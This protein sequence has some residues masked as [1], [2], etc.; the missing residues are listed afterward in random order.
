METHYD[1]LNKKLDKLQEKQNIHT[2][3]PE[4]S[5]TNIPR[6]INLTSIQFNDEKQKLLDLGLKYSMQKPKTTTWTNLVLETERAIRLLDDK[7]QDPFRK[8]AAKKLKQLYN[9]NH[10]NTTHKRQL[11]VLKQINQKIANGNGRISRADKGKRMVIIYTHDY[12]N[13]VPTFLSD[14]NFHTIPKDHIKIQKALRQCDRIIDTKQIRYLTQKKPDSDA[15]C[16]TKTAQARHSHKTSHQ[17]QN[18]PCT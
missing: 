12:N 6:T 14:N 13:K 5:P 16:P 1:R 3:T 17:Q 15:K 2:Q 10:H 9:T 18:H 8:I 4:T 7:L 11:Y